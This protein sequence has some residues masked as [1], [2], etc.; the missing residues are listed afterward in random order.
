MR[1]LPLLLVVATTSVTSKKTVDV[2][3]IT[4][5]HVDPWYAYTCYYADYAAL[6]CACAR[7]TTCAAAD[8]R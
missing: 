5:V 7:T 1:S 8:Q 4:D 2:W 6:M 3:H